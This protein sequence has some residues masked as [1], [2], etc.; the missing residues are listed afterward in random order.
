MDG[1]IMPRALQLL[2]I[3]ATA[4]A[5]V[6]NAAAGIIGQDSFET[7]KL[8]RIWI[9]A[10]D[11]S[12]QNSEGANATRGFARLSSNGGRLVG[13]LMIPNGSDHGLSEYSIEFYFRTRN[14][15][16]SQFC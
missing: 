12:F 10:H 5:F 13:T 3:A 7:S 15:T 2:S 16:N 11:V 14:A 1:K 8:S 6:L 9:Q 4:L